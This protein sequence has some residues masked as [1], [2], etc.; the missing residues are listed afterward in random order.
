[1]SVSHLFFSFSSTF[2]TTGTGRFCELDPQHTEKS[3]L[4]S[5]LFFFCFITADI[6]LFF[7]LLHITQ[8]GVGEPFGYLHLGTF[9]FLFSLQWSYDMYAT[10]LTF[11]FFFFFRALYPTTY[12]LAVYDF[13]YCHRVFDMIKY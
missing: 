1:M 5:V 7:S 11:V 13:F 12:S 9:F 6:L 4:F 10:S 8:H 2:S 3:L